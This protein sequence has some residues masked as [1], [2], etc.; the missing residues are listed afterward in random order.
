[1]PGQ[2]TASLALGNHVAVSSVLVYLDLVDVFQTLNLKYKIKCSK[3]KKRVI[4][5]TKE[6]I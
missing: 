2:L 1:M 4:F 5:Q 3:S 6:K